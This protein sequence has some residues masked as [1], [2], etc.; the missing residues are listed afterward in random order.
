MEK[1]KLAIKERESKTP[2]VLR[3]EGNIP[4]NC[5]WCWQRATDRAD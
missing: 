1:I 5:L 4:C 2:N 3:R